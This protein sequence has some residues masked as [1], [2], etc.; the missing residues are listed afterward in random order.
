MKTEMNDVFEFLDK[1]KN[2]GYKMNGSI[3]KLDM[4]SSGFNLGFWLRTVYAEENGSTNYEKELYPA[5]CIKV[6]NKNLGLAINQI[7]EEAEAILRN[8]R[9]RV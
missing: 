4:S 2:L 9:I 1:A 7:L 3:F 6:K 8:Y 5:I